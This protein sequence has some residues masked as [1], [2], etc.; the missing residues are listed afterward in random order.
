MKVGSGVDSTKPGDRVSVARWGKIVSDARFGAYQKYPLAI[1][2]NTA[3]IGPG[4]QLDDASGVIINLATVVSAL[5]IHM[6]LDRP[7]ITGK[8]AASGKTL[9]VYGGSSNLG[10]L[11]VKYVED[12]VSPF[13]SPLIVARDDDDCGKDMRYMYQALRSFSI[14][15]C[16]HTHIDTQSM[17]LLTAVAVQ[18]NMPRMRVIKS[19][20]H[21]RLRT[22]I[23]SRRVIQ[24]ILST[25]LRHRRMS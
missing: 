3:K 24:H 2:E 4:V 6:G 15:F 8:A 20:R 19:L 14:L 12:T 11:A 17:I 16:T 18:Q 22:S 21:L 9:L 23:S 25:T 7:P 13:S 5:S 1:E 10:G